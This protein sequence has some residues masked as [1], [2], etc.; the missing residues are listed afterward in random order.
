MAAVQHLVAQLAAALARDLA[1]AHHQIPGDGSFTD[2]LS[3]VSCR[4]ELAARRDARDTMA[5]PLW[6]SNGHFI[7][8]R[9]RVDVGA[10]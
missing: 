4:V 2:A 1:R 10:N 8:K 6:V 5:C 7:F 9:V 3:H